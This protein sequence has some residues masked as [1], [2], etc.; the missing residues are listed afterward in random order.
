MKVISLQSKLKIILRIFAVAFLICLLLISAHVKLMNCDDLL[1]VMP[2][3]SNTSEINAEALEK[4]NGDSFLLTYEIISKESI[5]ALNKNYEVNLKKTNYSYPFTMKNNL[6]KGS[7]FTEQDQKER[8]KSAVLNKAA[9][10]AMFGNINIC[11]SKIN[12]GQDEY[13]V[14]GVI[15]DKSEKESIYVPAACSGANPDSFAVKMEANITEEQV[16]NKCKSAIMDENDY[17]FTYLKKLE[18]LVYKISFS[19][20]KFA[21]ISILIFIYKISQV[22]FRENLNNIR[23]LAKQIYIIEL[24]RDH[25]KEVLEA[26]F[27]LIGMVLTI[28]LILNIT[29]SFIEYFLLFS[30]YMPFMKFNDSSDFSIIAS[31][32]KLN[33]YISLIIIIGFFT[34]IIIILIQELHSLGEENNV[35]DY[36]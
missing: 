35:R 2:I 3:P 29:I 18:G 32:L 24:V 16:K 4:L 28:I 7:F 6:I 22:R 31:N 34:N 8:K 12:T 5:K 25:F 26:V 30:D 11:G 10:Y 33:I 1:L 19:G 14:T 27:L 13:T 17:S 36:N 23:S 9:S 21:V 15:E 20:L